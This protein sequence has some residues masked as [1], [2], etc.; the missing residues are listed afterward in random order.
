MWLY[1]SIGICFTITR[2][3]VCVVLLCMILANGN[4]TVNSRVG[5]IA[6]AVFF[7]AVVLL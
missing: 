1:S 2:T 4:I 6:G 3:A 7:V 5:V